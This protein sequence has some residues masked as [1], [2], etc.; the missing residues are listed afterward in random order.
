VKLEGA[1]LAGYQ[2][3][4]IG[5]VRD[6]YIIGQID[7][8]TQRLEEKI[9]ARIRSIYGDALQDHDYVIKIRIYG[10][11]G[12]MGELEPVK[13]IRSHEL[14]L[15]IEAT[16]PSQELANS[17]M[18]VVRHQALHLPIKEWSGMMT[19]MACPYNPAYLKRGAIYRFNVNHVVE[20]D[21]P[22]EMF[23]MEMMDIG[24]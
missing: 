8:W 1:E 5:G 19:T 7:D 10:K 12:V 16:A 4:I 15:I 18:S 9:R 21:D 3:L 2:S 17:I 23:P 11:N 13:E 24:G 22:C 20:P 14:C 6:P